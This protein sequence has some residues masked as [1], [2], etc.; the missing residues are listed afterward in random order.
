MLAGVCLP[1]STGEGKLVT[2]ETKFSDVLLIK[3]EI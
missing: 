1:N 3:K 2:M